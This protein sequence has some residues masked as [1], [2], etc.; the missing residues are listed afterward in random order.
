MFEILYKDFKHPQ[1]L[2][3]NEINWVQDAKMTSLRHSLYHEYGNF[4]EIYI[5]NEFLLFTNY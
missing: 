4:M 3:I 1:K 5:F 2:Y